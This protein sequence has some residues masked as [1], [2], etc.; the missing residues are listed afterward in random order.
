M[1]CGSASPL[2]NL[3]QQRRRMLKSIVGWIAVA[4]PV[5]A[6][7][8][9]SRAPAEDMPTAPASKPWLLP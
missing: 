7:F 9:V 2:D 1:N 4:L 3:G 8:L 5:R 6:A